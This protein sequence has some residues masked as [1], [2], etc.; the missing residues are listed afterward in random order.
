M[1]DRI[2]LIVIDQFL[3]PLAVHDIQC[4]IQAIVYNRA[5]IHMADI[6]GED[7][8]CSVKFPEPDR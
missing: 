3:H 7:I 8:F 5:V 6:R 2:N 4:R 1:D